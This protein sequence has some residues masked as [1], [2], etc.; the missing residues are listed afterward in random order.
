MAGAVP[1]FGRC[2]PSAPAPCRAGSVCRQTH[3]GDSRCARF[4]NAA[5]PCAPPGRCEDMVSTRDG[6][7]LRTCLR[8]DECDV[9]RQDCADQRLG[10]YRS[11]VGDFCL[12]PGAVL[13]GAPCRLPNDCTRGSLCVG[14]EATGAGVCRRATD[15]AGPDAG[16]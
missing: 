9:G 5:V 3:H 2:D 6:R 4:C 8:T 16:R 11:F 1:D 15:D 13:D 10:C 12:P 14:V 7:A